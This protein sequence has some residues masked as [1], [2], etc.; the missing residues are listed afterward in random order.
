MHLKMWN[1]SK[2]NVQKMWTAQTWITDLHLQQYNLFWPFLGFQL[3]AQ[4]KHFCFVDVILHR[5]FIGMVHEQTT[6]TKTKRRMYSA[7][8]AWMIC[9][10]SET[11]GKCEK[12]KEKQ[13]KTTKTEL[14]LVSRTQ[15]TDS[16]ATT[17]VLS[18]WCFPAGDNAKS[19]E[20]GNSIDMKAQGA[21]DNTGADNSRTKATNNRLSHWNW[22][23]TTLQL[24][25]LDLQ[26]GQCF[27]LRFQRKTKKEIY[28]SF[29]SPSL[30]PVWIG[31]GDQ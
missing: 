19:S 9:T 6:I 8:I 3:F 14:R 15:L 5:L 7:R 2:A 12:K 17:S 29:F 27:F 26:H 4:K 18:Q 24:Q 30:G 13:K 23:S 11:W 16:Q 31:L 22:R 28:L 1:A 10:L 20:R 21:F 25:G